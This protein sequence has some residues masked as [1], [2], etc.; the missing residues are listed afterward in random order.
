MTVRLYV[1]VKITGA[2]IQRP[3]APKHS[4]FYGVPF[5][6]NS[7][8]LLF[9]HDNKNSRASDILK[10]LEYHLTYTGTFHGL[11]RRPDFHS[12]ISKYATEGTFIRVGNNFFIM[13]EQPSIYL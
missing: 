4:D 5:L 10:Y 13:L 7:Y 8:V 11:V 9:S 1:L 3:K 6:F 2:K 12:T